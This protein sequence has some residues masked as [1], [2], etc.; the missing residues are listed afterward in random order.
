MTTNSMSNESLN[1]L[2]NELLEA[3]SLGETMGILS[4]YNIAH[5]HFTA[6]V[7]SELAE[8]LRIAP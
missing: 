4:A 6:L 2:I 5:D 1:R 8:R 3:E 7:I